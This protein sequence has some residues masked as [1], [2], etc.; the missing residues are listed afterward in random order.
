MALP[1]MLGVIATGIIITYRMVDNSYGA[2][3]STSY[4]WL[5][6]A[7]I[8]LLVVVLVIASRARS[9][10]LPLLSQSARFGS[11]HG[12]RTPAAQMGQLRIHAC[13]G[14]RA[15]GHHRGQ[16]RPGQARHHPELALFLPLLPGR[17]LGRPD[18]MLRVWSGVALLAAAGAALALGRPSTGTRSGAWA[19]P[20]CC[21]SSPGRGPAAAGG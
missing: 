11:R 10:W 15:P 18:V 7:K 1:V 3:V 16:Y 6:D 2:L 5:L 8:A 14:H 21:W 17:H 13:A 12:R 4:G 9:T 20:P 19:S